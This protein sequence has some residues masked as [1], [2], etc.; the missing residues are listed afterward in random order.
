[1]SREDLGIV[2]RPNIS[3][4]RGALARIREGRSRGEKGVGLSFLLLACNRLAI[5]TS[6]GQRRYE[7]VVKGASNWARGEGKVVPPTGS[8]TETGPRSFLGSEAYTR[9]TLEQINFDFFDLDL[10]EMEPA[11][12]V[13]TLRTRTAVGNTAPLFKDVGHPQPEPIKITLNYR[14]LSGKAQVI[15][16]PYRYA[17]PE[18][19]LLDA[20]TGV[21]VYPF[22]ELQPLDRADLRRRTRKGGMRYVTASS[23]KAGRSVLLYMFAMDGNAMKAQIEALRTKKGWAPEEWQGYWVA[24]HD[25]PTG[26]PLSSGVIA[27]R[28]Y[29]RRLFA[30]LHVADLQLDVGRKSLA[31]GTVAMLNRILRDTWGVIN[32]VVKRMAPAPRNVKAGRLA[33]DRQLRI[34]RALPDL[35]FDVGIPYLKQPNQHVGVAAL[36]HELLGARHDALDGFRPLT[37]GVF[38]DDDALI[39]SGQPNGHEPLHVLFGV[40]SADIIEEVE[41]NELNA[42]TARLAVIW[43]L[44]EPSDGIEVT[45]VTESQDSATHEIHFDGIAGRDKPLRTIVLDTLLG[46]GDG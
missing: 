28:G 42:Q 39:Y 16:V 9:I 11:E 29:E 1:M 37:S 36:F 31:G 5:E 30:L 7:V 41:E 26:I 19:L 20:D 45:P 33:F 21:R 4:K 24:T 15:D 40:T 10:F 13:W 35:G 34:A 2:F 25:M 14:P 46:S 18:D 17:T 3:F 6:D 23:S 12:L 32:L 38:R 8:L 43:T 27:E 22:E 44:G